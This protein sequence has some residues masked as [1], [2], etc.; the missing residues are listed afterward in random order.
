VGKSQTKP[1]RVVQIDAT[2]AA[3]QAEEEL[4]TQSL[5]AYYDAIPMKA[6]IL[7]QG[8][9]AEGKLTSE[10]QQAIRTT[11]DEII[12]V[13]SDY[14]DTNPLAIEAASKVETVSEAIS[15]Q[16]ESMGSVLCVPSRSSL[17]EAASAMLA[18]I[19]EKRAIKAVVRPI[20]ISRSFCPYRAGCHHPLSLASTV[21]AERASYSGR[22]ARIR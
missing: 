22:A 1:A 4:K 18:Q 16:P 19:L 17:D 11:V 9:A 20:A 2:D 8:D 15:T 5:S 21:R 14:Q 6:L 7:A 13:L 12:E 10:K 3:D